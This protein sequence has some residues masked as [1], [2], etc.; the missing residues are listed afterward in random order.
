MKNDP[1]R[2]QPHVITTRFEDGEGVLIN[3][4]TKRYYRI[5]ET[6]LLVWQGL[7]DGLTLAQI[8]EQMTARYVVDAEQATIHIRA[9]TEAFQQCQ[10]AH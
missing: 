9:L 7:Q 3:V 6:G 2:P 10:L 1:I 8:S 4:K 5:N